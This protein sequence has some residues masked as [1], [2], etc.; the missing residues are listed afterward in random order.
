MALRLRGEYF[1]SLLDDCGHVD[2]AH[3][4]YLGISS[5]ELSYRNGQ[6]GKHNDRRQPN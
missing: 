5:V 6:N 1:G 4:F 3:G 2:F